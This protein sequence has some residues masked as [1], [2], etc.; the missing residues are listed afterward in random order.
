LLEPGPQKRVREALTKAGGETSPQRSFTLRAAIEDVRKTLRPAGAAPARSSG[1]KTLWDRLGGEIVLRKV[2]RDAGAAIGKDPKVDV[3]RGG[4][5]PVDPQAMEDR[6]VAFISSVTGG[7][8]KYTGRDMK[9]AHAGMRITDAQFNAVTS[10]IGAALKAN[11]VP[12]RESDELLTIIASTKKDI[13]EN[14]PPQPPATK[15]LWDRL[16]GAAAV[17]AVV[18]DFVTIAAKDP[19][20]NFTRGP[21]YKLDANAV[22]T[23][24]EHLVQFI[25]AATGGPLKYAGR[26]MKT[27]HAGMKIADA[28]FNAAAADLV[29]ALKKHK[30]AQPE[31]DAVMNA[32]AG[33]KKDI[34]EQK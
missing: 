5:F 4:K 20:V 6:L 7:P 19:K 34:V 18:H 24:E 9:T 8:I 13:V 1:A 3:T 17:K 10:Y 28:E 32:V 27:V 31:I 33:T 14:G 15:T 21:R 2:V 16:G 22:V 29:E 26:D 25:S 30:V 12:L 11:K 23:L